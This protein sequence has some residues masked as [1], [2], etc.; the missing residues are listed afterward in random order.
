MAVSPGTQQR[1]AQMAEAFLAADG[2]DDF[3]FGIKLDAVF[4]L[5]FFGDFLAQTD[6]AVADAVAMIF[7]IARGLGEFFHDRFRSRIGGVSH[8]QI[9]DVD[10]RD[11]LFVFHLIDASEKVRRQAQECAVK[12]QF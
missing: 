1:Q 2:G 4:R 5:I 10:A 9:D 3:G 7:G 6:D 11:S 8:P 12:R